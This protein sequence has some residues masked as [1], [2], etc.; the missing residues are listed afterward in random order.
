[1]RRG[2]LRVIFPTAYAACRL[3]MPASAALRQMR[4]GDRGFES[5]RGCNGRQRPYAGLMPRQIRDAAR[6]L[7]PANFNDTGDLRLSR[8][9]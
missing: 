7:C 2:A 6:E 9:A 4:R 1:V 8:V 3:I 5:W